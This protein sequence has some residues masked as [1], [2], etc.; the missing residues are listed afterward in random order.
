MSRSNSTALINRRLLAVLFLGF[1]SG[2]PL[3][4]TSSTLQAWFTE[5]GVNVLTIGLL[6]LLGLPYI[7]KFLWAPIIDHYELPF[8]G[9]RRGWILLSQLGVVVLL[10]ILAHQNPAANTKGMALIALAVAF[11]SA[12]LDIAITAYQTDVLT[13]EER[14]LGVAYYVFTYRIARSEE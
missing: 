8:L 10:L 9:K 3:A 12:S 4:L 5:A 13:P 7:L 1:A 2:L 11:F 14:G 6:S